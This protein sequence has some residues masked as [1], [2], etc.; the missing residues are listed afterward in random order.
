MGSRWTGEK[1]VGNDQKGENV[2][3]KDRFYMEACFKG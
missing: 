2:G 1:D 3:I